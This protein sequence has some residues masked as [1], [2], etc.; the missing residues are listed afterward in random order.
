MLAPA[1]IALATHQPHD[2]FLAGM[3]TAIGAGVV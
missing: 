2:A 3:A 1:P